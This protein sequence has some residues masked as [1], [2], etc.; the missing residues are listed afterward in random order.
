LGAENG[1]VAS[2]EA[3]TFGVSYV[4][5]FYTSRTVMYNIAQGSN[6]TATTNSSSVQVPSVQVPSV[7]ITSAE[8]TASTPSEASSTTSSKKSGSANLR[9]PLEYALLVFACLLLL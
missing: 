9:F 8:T 2:E 3:S 1:T 6:A 7:A 4:S 5:S